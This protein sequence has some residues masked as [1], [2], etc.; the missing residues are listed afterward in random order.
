MN[1]TLLNQPNG[2]SPDITVFEKSLIARDEALELAAD[3][4]EKVIRLNSLVNISTAHEIIKETMWYSD[5][6]N[7]EAKKQR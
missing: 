4:L 1:I 7:Q 6:N 5:Y 3:I 2:L